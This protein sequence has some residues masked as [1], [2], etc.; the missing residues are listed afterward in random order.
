MRRILLTCLV[1]VAGFALATAGFAQ[2]VLT[3][4]LTG[5]VT[6]NDGQP[7]PGV[8]VTATSPALIGDRTAVSGVNGDF[9]LRGLPPGQYTVKFTLEGMQAVERT[10]T[11]LLGGTSRADAV[12]EVAAAE[13][14]IVV[15]GE[16]P[17]ALETTTV[18]ANFK[19]E[20]IDALPITRTPTN[21]AEL[22]PG[23]T[24]NTPVA[25]QV[26]INGGMAY[27]NAILI[28]GVNMQDNVFGQTNNLFI[29]DAIEETQVMTSGISAEFGGFS[30][31]VVNTI[32][33]S[34][35]N[36]FTGTFRVD[37]DQAEWRDE[38]P[39]EKSRGITR[40]SDLNKTYTETLGGPILRDRI[41]FFLA[42]RQF[43]RDTARTTAIGGQPF[44]TSQENPRYEI[45]LTGAITSNHTVQVSYINNDRKDK[46][47]VQLNPL[48]VAAVI[49]NGEFPN[50]G[51]SI[52]YSGVFT[53][54]LYG[55]LRWSEKA[56]Q[57]KGLGG[58]NPDIH[59]S[60]FYS[61]GLLNGLS[62]LYHAPYFD[63]T[64]PENRDN[65]EWFG[66]L[67]YFLS[68]AK[69]GSHDMKF[70]IERYITTRTGGNSQSPSNYVFIT[71][72]LADADGNPVLGPDGR[73]IPIF[74]PGLSVLQN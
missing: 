69:G 66:S 43:T 26:A 45:K 57:F 64:D 20:Q 17:S 25:G 40:E 53:N 23:L 73:F 12:M 38:T 5:S 47:N 37:F 36:Q 63:A 30:G 50:D 54:S 9:V 41:W 3:G 56:F 51:T 71:D 59:E 67:S 62:G 24:D 49:P 6:S 29:E 39:F 52:N 31:G 16:A 33:K 8:T 19:K 10:S 18:G 15:T 46:N 70:G 68:T 60:P 13:E 7:L 32:T 2:G 58:T 22:S 28:N 11:V 61:Y 1:V 21:I 72:F 4:N 27:D 48:E 74:T 14:T 44:I 42:A 65:E 35:G 55:E 34:G